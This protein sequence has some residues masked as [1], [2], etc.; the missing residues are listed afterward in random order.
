MSDWCH[1]IT[2]SLHTIFNCLKMMNYTVN[3]D[4]R[5][6]CMLN[7]SLISQSSYLF[8]NEFVEHSKQVVKEVNID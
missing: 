1:N 8:S 2:L 5:N 7:N 4:K 6:I 3:P